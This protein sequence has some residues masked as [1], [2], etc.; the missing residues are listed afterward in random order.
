MV[1][2][3]EALLGP[4]T[5]R[6]HE[7]FKGEIKHM[8]FYNTWLSDAT[9]KNKYDLALSMNNSI[10]GTIGENAPMEIREKTII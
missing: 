8:R 2:I 3:G 6:N 9:I 5:S 10:S 7:R 4:E 1:H